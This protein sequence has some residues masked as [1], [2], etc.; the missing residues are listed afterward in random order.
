M[1]HRS[2][3]LII[4]SSVIGCLAIGAVALRLWARKVGRMKIGADDALIIIGLVKQSLA[5][6]EPRRLLTIV[7]FWRSVCAFA[8]SSEQ[9]HLDLEIM[10]LISSLPSWI[11]LP[12][13]YCLDMA[14]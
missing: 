5:W 3:K 13:G 10:S 9:R 2:A 8:T 6:L 12:P 4:T 1:Y 7:K 11:G 14:K